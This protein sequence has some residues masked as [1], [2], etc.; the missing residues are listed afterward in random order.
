MNHT[1]ANY[2]T[3][4]DQLLSDL[5][6]INSNRFNNLFDISY[7]LYNENHSFCIQFKNTVFDIWLDNNPTCKISFKSYW[8]TYIQIIIINELAIKYNV[9]IQS[10]GIKS[11]PIVF[12]SYEHY[13]SSGYDYESQS[14]LDYELNKIP[15]ELR[16]L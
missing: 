11:N 16:N 3:N 13:L 12:E 10:N 6:E 14:E 5:K 15:I 8:L 1:S 2:T 7:F 4:K 9:K